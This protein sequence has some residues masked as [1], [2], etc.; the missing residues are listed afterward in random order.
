MAR[1]PRPAP[2]SAMALPAPWVLCT[3]WATLLASPALAGLSRVPDLF[4]AANWE[5][6]RAEAVGDDGG[7]R[8]A[9]AELWRSRLAADPEAALAIL[10]EGLGQRRLQRP[11]RARLALEAADLELGRGRPGDALEVLSPLLDDGPEVPGAVPVA[12]ARALVALGRGPRARELLVAVRTADPAYGVSRALLG[13]IALSQGDATGAVGWYDQAEQADPQLRRRL[14]AG[15]CRAL[16]RAGRGREAAALAAQLEAL[17]P[18]SLALLEIRR[19]LAEAGAGDRV[20]RRDDERPQPAPATPSGA[21][22]APRD[23]PAAVE[24]RADDTPPPPE[25]RARPE[26]APA[27]YVLQFGAFTER[28]RAADFLGRRRSE[29]PGLRLEEGV[30]GRGQPVWRARAGGW[31]E[32]TAAEAAA[33]AL[34]D[35]LGLDVIVVDREATARAGA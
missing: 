27:R 15:R 31:E 8:P 26:A 17:D 19:A 5:Q 1:L 33:R 2:A 24:A 35:R 14:A 30:D 7:A 6:A 32:R 16:L 28:T 21:R 9:E 34:G 22:E 18:G 10:R 23:A 11:L 3:L 25:S 20:A 12:A 29:I 4:A 13:D